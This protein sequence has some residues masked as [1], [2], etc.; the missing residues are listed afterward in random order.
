[1]DVSVGESQPHH[2]LQMW[3]GSDTGFLRNLLQTFP[4]LQRFNEPVTETPDGY[5]RYSE[6]SP[7]IFVFGQQ[8]VEFD[9]TVIGLMAL[10]WVLEGDW[11]SFTASQKGE[12][13]LSL[14]AFEQI[15][16][17]TRSVLASPSLIEAMITYLVLA[18][19]GKV[20]SVSLDIQGRLSQDFVD[21]DISLRHALESDEMSNDLFPSFSRLQVKE[22]SRI[23][24]SLAADFNIGQFIQGESGPAS[25]R[26]LFVLDKEALDFYLVHAFYDI[27]GAAGHF[28]PA[29]SVIVNERFWQSF[30]RALAA[31]ES[32][33]QGA[34]ECDAY[35]GFLVEY[36]ADLGLVG[37]SS[38]DRHR[39]LARLAA[40]YRGDSH[41]AQHLSQ[42]F[43]ALPQMTQ[44][45][46]IYELN[47]SGLGKELSL[48]PYYGPA[49]MNNV[50]RAASTDDEYLIM[51][52]LKDSLE[53]LARIFQ[54]GRAA[55]KG[56]EG[57]GVVTLF[58]LEL[59]QIAKEPKM[60]NEVTFEFRP[61]GEHFVAFL[62]SE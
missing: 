49:L 17:W 32:L 38:S 36:A 37:S 31:I 18:D 60:L 19:M 25:L 59:A 15:K 11:K 6:Q 12:D 51:T 61:V 9:R 34:S 44:D 2:E 4:E 29:G 56:R 33:R 30:R 3:G 16:T 13:A 46:L 28:E 22:R 27:A 39:A 62:T 42:A 1:M 24:R 35:W 21:H 26:G 48:V 53:V 52:A 40:I 41:I 47:V 23:A 10:R 45:V 55:C 57:P 54:K 50:V 43:D 7:S 5:Q 20:Q 58:V 8:A 14:D